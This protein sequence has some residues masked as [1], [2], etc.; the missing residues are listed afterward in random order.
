MPYF[1]QCR[2]EGTPLDLPIANEIDE[3]V[4]VNQKNK[5]IKDEIRVCDS[6]LIGTEKHNAK[7]D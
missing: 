3:K 4:Y 6:Y 1:Y 5:K 7:R 2:L